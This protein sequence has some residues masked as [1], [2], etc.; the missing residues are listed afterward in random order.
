MLLLKAKYA[1]VCQQLQHNELT[2]DLPVGLLAHYASS[3]NYYDLLLRGNR[4][5]QLP[6]ELS[7]LSHLIVLHLPNQGLRGTI[8]PSIGELVG[9]ETLDLSFNRLEGHIPD[10]I[11]CLRRQELF[12]F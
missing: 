1:C 2:G 11:T 6:R 7:P 5:L 3:M 8:P 9:L 10:S 4:D 12:L